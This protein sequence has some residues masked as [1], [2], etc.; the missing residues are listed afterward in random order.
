M[1]SGKL[2]QLKWRNHT[3]PRLRISSD[4]EELMSLEIA[5]T[6]GAI[7]SMPDKSDNDISR[8]KK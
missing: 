2:I 6:V 3:T 4:L 5:A 1:V 8:P 7:L